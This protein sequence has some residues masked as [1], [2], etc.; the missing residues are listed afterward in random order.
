[1]GLFVHSSKS[2]QM[3][4]FKTWGSSM[5]LAAI[6]LLVYFLWFE[7]P[8]YYSYFS[9]TSGITCVYCIQVESVRGMV[10]VPLPN[11]VAHQL[12]GLLLALV[13][14]SWISYVMWGIYAFIK[15]KSYNQLLFQLAVL[16]LTALAFVLAVYSW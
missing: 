11:W 1:M 10:S 4:S 13:Y 2:S 16:V 12:A 9:N 5:L 7:E 3:I 6:W 15:W 8:W 14:I